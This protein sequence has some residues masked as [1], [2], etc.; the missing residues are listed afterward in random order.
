MPE[1]RERKLANRRRKFAS[2]GK[3]IRV[4][5]FLYETLDKRRHGRS[6]DYYLRKLLGMPDRK[7]NEQ[8]LIEGM[9]E[10]TTGIFLLKLPETSWS[11]LETATYKLAENMRLKKKLRTLSPPIRM[12]ET[13]GEM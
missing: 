2:K 10:T 13:R 1:P 7:G 4:S 5:D 9:L 12:R 8:A 3:A 11:K 6:W